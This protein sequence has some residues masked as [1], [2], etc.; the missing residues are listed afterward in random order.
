MGQLTDDDA[1]Y[2]PGPLQHQ[3]AQDRE[4]ALERVARQLQ[5]EAYQRRIACV[6]ARRAKRLGHD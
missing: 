4:A 5:W 3:A 2:E 1:P 6:L